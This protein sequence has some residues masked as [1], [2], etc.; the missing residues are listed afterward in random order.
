MVQFFRKIL[1]SLSYFQ[2][3]PWDTGI[4]PPELLAFLDNH[5]PGRALDLGCGTGTNVLTMARRGWEA[6]GVDFAPPAI[7][8]ARRKARR[9]GL[10]ATFYVDDVTR[11]KRITGRFDLVLDMGCFHSLPAD[12]RAEYVQ[13]LPGLLLPGATYLLYAFTTQAI[14]EQRAISE[15]EIE[16]FQACLR[17]VSRVDGSERGRRSSAWFTFR[18]PESE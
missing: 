9:A 12:K 10:D 8:A 14:E 15:V 5:P 13:N 4:S 6:F 3:P 7:S 18:F 2:D 17:L 16:Q 11:L 1:F